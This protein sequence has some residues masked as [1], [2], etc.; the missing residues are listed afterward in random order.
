MRRPPPTASGRGPGRALRGD[1]HAGGGQRLHGPALEP[2]VATAGAGGSR[3]GS[4]HE[5]ERHLDAVSAS[6][7]GS[8]TWRWNRWAASDLQPKT[9]SQ[10]AAPS[11]SQCRRSRS[12][13]IRAE[14][15]PRRGPGYGRS[16][17]NAS[18]ARLPGRMARAPGPAVLGPSTRL[19]SATPSAGPG[20]GRPENADVRGREFRRPPPADRQ[21][22]ARTPR[23]DIPIAV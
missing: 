9:A 23:E 12:R 2:I 13:T 8:G 10:C 5:V 20:P 7:S 14:A 17:S 4:G 21:R 11:R 19:P 3:S 1:G 6:G 16:E 15:V 18:L 22:A